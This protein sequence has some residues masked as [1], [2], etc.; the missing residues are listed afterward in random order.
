MPFQKGNQLGKHF[1]AGVS[2]NPGGRPK[3]VI[4]GT[5]R[6]GRVGLC[7]VI[8]NALAKAIQDGTVQRYIQ[9][10][11]HTDAQTFWTF[12]KTVIMPLLPRE[13]V[14]VELETAF[15]SFSKRELL[16][17]AGFQQDGDQ[18]QDIEE[19]NGTDDTTETESASRD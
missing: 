14:S 7:K 13:S 10:M 5:V 4:G 8:D 18:D 17:I 6:G 9:E 2:G 12:F 11:I 3:L 16:Q 1:P 19:D 15:A